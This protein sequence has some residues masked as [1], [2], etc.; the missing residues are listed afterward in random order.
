[1]LFDLNE[2]IVA[3]SS[4]PGY[5]PIGIIRLSGPAAFSIISNLWKSADGELITTE[6]IDKN[7]RIYLSGYLMLNDLEIPGNVIFFKGPN[8]YTSEDMVELYLPGS[9]KLLQM[10]IDSIKAYPEIRDAQAGEFT[11]R[12]FLNGRIDL[13]EAEAVAEVIHASGDAQLKAAENLLSGALHK[14]C[15]QFST[16]IAELLALVEAGIDFSDQEDISFID[17]DSLKHRL[18]SLCADIESLISDSVSW[19]DLHYLPR[20]VLVGPPN[21][22]KSSL[23][24]KLAKVDRS[25]VSSIAGTTRDILSAPMDLSM[26]ECLLIDTPGLGTVDDVLADESQHRVTEVLK[27]ADLILLIWNPGD[28]DNSQIVA[29]NLKKLN[30]QHLLVVYNK[31]D[32]YGD[33]IKPDIE[34]FPSADCLSVSAITGYNLDK[35]SLKLS[36][37]LHFTDIANLSEAIAL[38]SRQHTNLV[39]TS[40]VLSQLLLSLNDGYF[41][42]E[43]VALNLREALD[44]IGA[45]SGEIA[46]DDVL[47]KIFSNFCI[48][49]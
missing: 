11:A 31:C 36:E 46:S 39:H 35:F 21:A 29:N 25:I 6:Y 22:G 37:H 41:E 15:S 5:S 26:G 9:Q 17:E 20:V 3:I 2:T 48:G 12:A 45:I 19:R 4:V 18:I 23:M 33:D 16:R 1:M 10:V 47:G 13:T 43:I 38:T 42:E 24:N 34:S 28:K 49:K 32:I 30:I 8:S 7:V 27:N 44:H 14:K 40:E